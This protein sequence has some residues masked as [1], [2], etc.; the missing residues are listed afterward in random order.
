MALPRAH[1]LARRLAGG[2]TTSEQLVT[3]YLERIRLTEPTLH[4][5]VTV[6]GDQALA[7]AKASDARRAAGKPLSPFDGVP[8]AIKDNM[9]TRGVRT[10]CSSR[11]LENFVPPFDGTVVEKLHGAGL[12]IL[13]KA[14]LD[15]FAM[16]SSSE[17]SAFGVTR[18]P[19][20]T[21]RVP[22]GSSAGSASCVAAG[23]APWSLGSDTG[24]SIRQPASFC[25]LVGVKPTYGRV[26]RYGLVAFASSLDQIGPMTLDVRDAAHLMDL[27]S[28]HDPKDSTSARIP[29]P[30]HAAQLEAGSLKGKRVA[31]PREFFEADG[32][33]PEVAA[34]V[35]AAVE[36]LAALGAEIVDVSMPHTQYS[37]SCY[38]LVATAEAS[39]NLAR[40]DGAHYGFRA[41]ETR[42]IVEMFSRSRAQGFGDEVKRRI[43][44]G[45]H[46]L[47][48]GYFDAYYL[49]ALKVRTL[50]KR[51]YDEALAKADL[52]V[53][54]TS[55]FTA[56]PIGAKS[57]DPLSMYLCDI[58]T[59]SLNLAGY[60]GLSMPV[61]FD[62][63]GLPIGLQ[64]LGGAFEEVK[65][66]QAAWHL[67]QALGVV[68]SRE[69]AIAAG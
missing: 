21:T 63:K 12:V 62:S 26:S 61:G 47:S 59:L 9:I 65:V 48:A 42:N 16:G 35:N 8:I 58:F 29:V 64:L 6:T 24:G 30:A 19:W 11:I 28:G 4:S 33:D 44:I 43:M 45:T 18:N 3:S 17:N 23:Q 41:A 49:K 68:G 46:A 5:F 10:T 56:F 25:G 7:A 2:D 60:S 40:Y 1:E 57:A 69:P 27:I 53:A 52:I 22:G 32:I 34:S 51:D 14:N 31:R 66:L 55:P 15:E 54:P 38:Y 20:D 50:I 67:E 36:Q 13:G 39:S 37:I